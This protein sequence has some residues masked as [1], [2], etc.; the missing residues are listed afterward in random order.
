MEYGLSS[1][2]EVF[3]YLRRRVPKHLAKKAPQFIDDIQYRRAEHVF[4]ADPI[5]PVLSRQQRDLTFLA[6]ESGKPKVDIT[7]VDNFIFQPATRVLTPADKR[8]FKQLVADHQIE[9]AQMS[10]F[11]KIKK[12]CHNMIGR[13]KRLPRVQAA[14]YTMALLVFAGGL[15][16]SIDGWHANG[17]VHAQ[18]TR[19]TQAVATIPQSDGGTAPTT[20]TNNST[21]TSSSSRASAYA[22]APDEPKYLVIKNIKVDARVI[23]VGKLDDGSIGTPPP[24]TNQ[25]GWFS[26]SSKPGQPGAMVIDGHVSG[27]PDVGVFFNLKKLV[28]G[29]TVQ[30]E[31]GDGQKITYQVVK[32]QS[33]DAANVDTNA[34]LN[35]VDFSKPG[36]NLI[37]CAGKYDPKS[38]EFNQRI[39]VFT[40]QI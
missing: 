24:N 34:L 8:R 3:S 29:D 26:A 6:H 9:Q 15:V 22:A 21:G 14:L 5:K 33:Y 13:F 16:V 38:D 35:P 30:V 2:S 36:L 31:R 11:L 39:I 40:V 27:L 37:T 19:L 32:T 1:D 23:S 20:T 28:A 10:P 12:A 7:P 25:V 18:V 17:A 4:E